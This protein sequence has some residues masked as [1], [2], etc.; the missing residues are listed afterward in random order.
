MFD[1]DFAPAKRK[2]RG[3]TFQ[4]KKNYFKCLAYNNFFS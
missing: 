2:L 1:L 4:K 3:S